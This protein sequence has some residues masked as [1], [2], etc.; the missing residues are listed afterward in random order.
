MENTAE[1]RQEIYD[2]IRESSKDEY[3]L[4]EIK[5]LGFWQD[6]EVDIETVIGVLKTES[7]LSKKLNKL[8]RENNINNPERF[9]AQRHKERKKASKER[10]KETK[11]K[12]EQ[13]RKEKAE[14]WIQT[15]ATDII[16][17]GANYSHTLNNKHTLVDRLKN[18]KLP[19]LKNANDVANAMKISIG[20][21]RFLAF[22]RKNSNINHYKR[23][24]IAKK[25]GG[26]RLISAPQPKLKK[27]QHW[28]L[29]NILEQI[30]VHENAH[31]CVKGR[32]IKS[33]ALP[34]VNKAVVI[35]QDLKN[36]FPTITY[37]R[38]KGMFKSFGYSEQVA[39]IF[40][41]LCSEPKILELDVLGKDYF[42]QRG[43][44]F[45][46]QGSP[47][48]PA[49]ANVICKKLDHRLN[50]LAH[51][52]GF[53]YSRYVDDVTFSGTHEQ[54]KHISALLKYSGKIIREEN[55]TLH[56][57]KL[58]IMK[59]GVKQEVTGVVVNEK[60]NMDRA[61]LKR[62]RALLH[63]IERDGIQDKT[64]TGKGNVLAQIHGYANHVFQINPEKG[65]PLKEQV[66]LILEKH[67]YK[68]TYQTKPKTQNKSI[69]DKI[70]SIL[71]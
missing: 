32:S 14:K 27:A 7:E 36:F 59:K 42:A 50:G 31:G 34:H 25:S 44:R 17:L 55:F 54:Y 16:Y 57:E 51:K 2:K 39:V 53:T 15:K 5:R 9:I 4:Q 37:T 63:Q 64:W 41:L 38:I 3:I 33:N 67:N 69:W 12:R 68:E 70:K 30:Q 1:R 48:S 61:T 71:K 35:N 60:P 6:K 10:Q 56:P 47:C 13:L 18:N 19:I 24:T 65:T 52:Y 8:I 11:A 29:E 49:I 43:D 62:F 22:S 20:E 28:I 66:S 45:L 26:T 23:F 46:P 21:L 40:A 58:R